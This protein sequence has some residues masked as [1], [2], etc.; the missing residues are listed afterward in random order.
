MSLNSYYCSAVPK[1]LLSLQ[2]IKKQRA[3]GKTQCNSRFPVSVK[4][5]EYD[6]DFHELYLRRGQPND[7]QFSKFL[8]KGILWVFSNISGLIS[9]LPDG[10]IYSCNSNF[11]LMLFGFSEDELVGKVFYYPLQSVYFLLK[12]SLVET[13][14]LSLGL[15]RVQSFFEFWNGPTT[16]VSQLGVV[17]LRPG[18]MHLRPTDSNYAMLQVMVPYTAI[19]MQASDITDIRTCSAAMEKHT[20]S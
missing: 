2:H 10:K 15:K 6:K 12:I 8:Y 16:K 7:I 4:I 19:S 20:F 1:Y 14:F 9:V 18:S 5:S 11:S 17:C 13:L 3:T